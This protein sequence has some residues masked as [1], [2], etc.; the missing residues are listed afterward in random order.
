MNVQAGEVDI[1]L[2][3]FGAAGG[4]GLRC[5]EFRLELSL[6]R[7]QCSARVAAADRDKPQLNLIAAFSSV[8]AGL[9]VGRGAFALK[10]ALLTRAIQ[11]GERA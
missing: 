10:I 6:Y 4:L 9:A 5:G 7:I 2:V 3:L 1:D 8:Q 11:D